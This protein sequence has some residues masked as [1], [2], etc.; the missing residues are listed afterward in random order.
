M[1]PNR[2]G[3]T[4]HEAPFIWKQMD[5]ALFLRASKNSKDAFGPSIT[6]NGTHGQRAAR[7]ECFRPPRVVRR[8]LL[9]RMSGTGDDGSDHASNSADH[10][11][12]RQPT[13]PHDSP[14]L[15]RR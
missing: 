6:A 3:R 2:V 9:S 7:Q 1:L 14:A 8:R 15:C 10:D 5:G 4:V 11:M 12:A 13:T